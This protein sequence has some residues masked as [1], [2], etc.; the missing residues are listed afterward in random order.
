MSPRRNV[1]LWSWTTVPGNS[2]VLLTSCRKARRTATGGQ[3]ARSSGQ[4]VRSAVD[5]AQVCTLQITE[6]FFGVVGQYRRSA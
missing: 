4:R 5:A 6:V 2:L 1:L 3:T